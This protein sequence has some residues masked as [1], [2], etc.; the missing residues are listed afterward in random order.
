MDL[1]QRKLTKL[2]WDTTEV[3]VSVTEKKV[4]ELISDGYD[5]VNIKINHNN[6]LFMFLKIEF[7]KEME[8]YLYNKYFNEKIQKMKKTYDMSFLTQTVSSNIQIKKADMIRLQNNTVDTIQNVEIYEIVLLDRLESL[9]NLYKNKNE[10]WQSYYFVLYKLIKNTVLKLNKHVLHVIQSTLEF[11]EDKINISNIV[12]NGYEYIE[13]NNDLLKFNDLSLY[14]HQKKIF[15]LSKLTKPKL[16]LY[17]APTG[18]GK[19]LTPIGLAKQHKI[20]FVCAARHVGLALARS[21]ISINKKIAFAFGCNDASDIRLHY[22]SAKEYTKNTKS[23]GIWK[24]DNSVGDKVEIIISDIKSYLSAMY[25]MLSFNT[26]EEII[27]YWDEPT[28]TMDYDTH[29]FHDIIQ[30][31]WSENLIPNVILSSATLPKEHELA[32]T[33]NDFKMKFSGAFVESIISHDCIKSIP[34]INKNG[35]VV[36][37]HNLYEDYDDI[38]KVV[39]HCENYPTLLRYFDLKEVCQFIKHVNELDFIQNSYKINRRFTS[40]DDISMQTIKQYYLKI[41]GNIKPG[42]WGSIYI[43]LKSTIA[44]R[45]L[46][47]NYID[48]KGIKFKKSTSVGPGMNNNNNNNNTTDQSAIRNGGLVRVNSV[49]TPSSN[50]NANDNTNS[51]IGNSAIYITTKDAYTLTDGPTIFLANDVEKIAKFYIQQ[52][53]IP[54]KIMETILETIQYNNTVNEKVEKLEKDMEDMLSK[55]DKN[56]NDDDGKGKRS[57]NKNSDKNDREMENNVK[58]KTIKQELEMLYSMIKVV[59]F[60]ETLVPNKPAHLM[61]WAEEMDT[62]RAFTSNIDND[63]IEKIMLLNNVSD[64][65]KILLLMGIGVFVNHENM[66]NDYVEIM[67]N[68]ADKQLLY[69]IIA[70]S[71]YIYGTNYQFCHGYLSKDMKLT[72]E[73]IIQALGRIGRNNIQQDYTIRF[74]DN[75][76]IIKLFNTE[77]EKPEIKNMN[78][79][80]CSV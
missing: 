50:S 79:L 20:I 4:L 26:R 56:D 44:K 12:I 25:Y 62:K 80:F 64:N 35:Y 47:N 63:I 71:D 77:T 72:Q 2:E 69:L 14:E 73:K 75:E 15:A 39:K 22:F 61:K 76:Q 37:P 51:D 1:I 42:T 54:S 58:I 55:T 21:A 3:P 13:K 11:Y 66:N 45:I 59:S 70:S 7:S 27:T 9:L 38:I 43:Y 41:L 28:I 68:L 65:W 30:K 60:N 74:R 19:T 31:N 24:V 57:R 10:K 23:G 6:S 18:T 52:S 53:H 46:P 36:L 78:K 29:E 48:E 17:I 16:L 33:I 49:F 8:D 67:K 5:N 40:L 32:T 34:I